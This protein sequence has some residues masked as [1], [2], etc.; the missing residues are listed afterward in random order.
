MT[1]AYETHTGK[2]ATGR[3]ARRGKAA[4]G[5]PRTPPATSTT[6]APR[7]LTDAD[8]GPKIAPIAALAGAQA[9]EATGALPSLALAAT[10]LW[11]RFLRFDPN[12]PNW[13]DRDR[14][15][16]SSTRLRAITAALERLSGQ[17]TITSMPS[18]VPGGPVVDVA[19]A[20]S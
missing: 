12:E 19:G 1:G 20:P 7:A 5:S 4:Q 18:G 11:A 8:I 10:V 15:V 3:A 17:A 9:L 6:S 16:I 13:P 2:A 14:V